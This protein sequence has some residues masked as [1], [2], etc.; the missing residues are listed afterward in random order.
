MT[1]NYSG[2][3][4]PTAHEFKAIGWTALKTFVVTAIAQLIAYGTGVFDLSTDQWKGVAASA[5]TAV[6]MV[7]V[8]F[9][10]PKYTGYGVGKT[11]TAAS[12]SAN[13]ATAP[14]KD[15]S[16][17]TDA[18]DVDITPNPD[19]VPDVVDGHPD[20]TDVPYTKEK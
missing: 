12:A 11:A 10:N 6:L 20:E 2:D 13:T 17:N 5:V 19:F 18:S 16:V 1:I 3:R 8:N 4:V 14:T 15:T 7:V 9:L